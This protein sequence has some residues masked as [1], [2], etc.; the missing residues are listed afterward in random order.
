MRVVVFQGKDVVK[1]GECTAEGSVQR[2]N[3]ELGGIP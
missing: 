3:G 2:R 1:R